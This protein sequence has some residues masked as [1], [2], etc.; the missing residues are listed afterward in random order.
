MTVQR[1]VYGGLQCRDTVE[2]YLNIFLK[3]VQECSS[4]PPKFRFVLVNV[5]LQII[6]QVFHS[7]IHSSLDHTLGQ[8]YTLDGIPVD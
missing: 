5:P 2:F 1:F 4:T 7:F 6:P 3:V 8:K